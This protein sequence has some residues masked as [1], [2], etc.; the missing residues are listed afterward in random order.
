MKDT[1]SGELP[2]AGLGLGIGLGLFPWE[3]NSPGGNSPS[4][5]RYID[6]QDGISV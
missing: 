2:P 3:G 1:V 6:G 4:T 5:E